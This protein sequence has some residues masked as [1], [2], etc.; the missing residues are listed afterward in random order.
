MSEQNQRKPKRMRPSRLLWLVLIEIV[1][2][3]ALFGAYRLFITRNTDDNRG[4]EE[5]H[6]QSEQD[7]PE[8]KDPTKEEV[9]TEKKLTPEEEAALKEQERLQKEIQERL[10]RIAQADRVAL[11]YDYEG[12]INLIKEYKGSE[13]DYKVYPVLVNAIERLETEQAALL[14]LGGSYDSVTQINHIF[15]H[16]LIADN[17]KAFD[18]DYDAKG[19]NMYMTTTSE[20]IKLLQ[21][22]YE[23]GY[24]LVNISD[25]TKKVKLDDGSTEY[26]EGD[27]LLQKGKKPFVISVDDVSYYEY[28]EGDG[29]ATRIVLDEEGKPTCEMQQEDG[30]AITGQFDVVPIVDAF[31]KEHPD[32]S[33][34]GAKGLLALT[35]YEGILGYRTNDETSETYEEDVKAVKEVAEALKADGWE[36]ASH[37]W[38]HKNLQ[39]IDLAFLKRDTNRWLTEV[40]P[41]IGGSDVLVFPYGVDFETTIGTYSGDKYH[42][43]KESG[44]NVF[45]GVYSKPWMHIKK[46]YVRMTRRPIDGQAML[47]FPERLT[48]LFNPTDILDPERPARNW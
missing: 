27:I 35:G 36:F 6:Q 46:D 17:S 20:L 25:L 39:E 37:S 23:D 12:A 26:R 13:G 43:L 45:L 5:Q 10:E 21:K 15:F 24:V 38:G 1:I 14:P 34:K 2:L 8:K 3:L 30:T 16:S 22:M 28:M 41:L 11:G 19:Y 29:F 40:A 4:T 18:D 44:F 48:D 7:E 32:F 31:V 47:E 9:E 33:Y 42:Y